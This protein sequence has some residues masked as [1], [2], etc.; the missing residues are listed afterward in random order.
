MWKMKQL[1]EERKK[2]VAKL[3]TFSSFVQNVSFRD[4]VKTS[5]D[6]FGVKGYVKNID[7][8]EVEAVFE[9]E[10]KCSQ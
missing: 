10:D 1:K 8:G 9:G 4:F 3:V 5:A 7:N 6:E 2:V